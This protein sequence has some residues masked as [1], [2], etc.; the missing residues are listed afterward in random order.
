MNN[1]NLKTWP[2]KIFMRAEFYN[3]RGLPFN[4]LCNDVEWGD[5]K[6]STNDVEYVRKDLVKE[7]K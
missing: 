1:D 5:T 4:E 6:C 7:M 2:E 3:Q